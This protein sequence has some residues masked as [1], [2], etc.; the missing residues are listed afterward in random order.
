MYRF[1]DNAVVQADFLPISRDFSLSTK[2]FSGLPT[3]VDIFFQRHAA[4]AEI[5]RGPAS[6]TD[7]D[8]KNIHQTGRF[9]V[10]IIEVYSGQGTALAVREIAV[11]DDAKAMNAPLFLGKEVS[12]S[13]MTLPEALRNEFVFALHSQPMLQHDVSMSWDVKNGLGSDAEGDKVRDAFYKEKIEELAQM[14]ESAKEVLSLLLAEGR[15]VFDK[16]APRL[17]SGLQ[18]CQKFEICAG[19]I[20]EFIARYAA[21]PS[22]RV[23]EDLGLKRTFDRRG[24][25]LDLTAA[26]HHLGDRAH[27]GEPTQVNQMD[28]KG[29]F[30]R[31]LDIVQYIVDTV[32]AQEGCQMFVTPIDSPR[33]LPQVRPNGGIAIKFNDSGTPAWL[34]TPLGKIQFCH[35][36]GY[37]DSGMAKAMAKITEELGLVRISPEQHTGQT[38]SQ[39]ML[40]ITKDLEGNTLPVAEINTADSAVNFFQSQVIWRDL[41]PNSPFSLSR[42]AEMNG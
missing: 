12:V 8:I 17:G 38:T 18:I 28:L 5:L 31:A 3:K 1:P 42:L 26:E 32:N 34:V 25:V 39:A 20:H 6:F 37:S 10:G 16:I 19:N 33:I 2:A 7:Q 29:Y 24:L 30:R 21:K 35:A 14:R 23:I 11:S 40:A 15:D 36:L 9:V 4:Q 13:Y 22:P 27:R 41:Y